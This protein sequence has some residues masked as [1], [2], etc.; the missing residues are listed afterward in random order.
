MKFRTATALLTVLALTASSALAQP[1]QGAPPPPGNAPPPGPAPG[2]SGQVLFPGLPKVPLQPLLDRVA[3]DSH[4]PF[5]VDGRVAPDLYHG[6]VRAED[7]TY[8]VL[9]SLL[10]ANDLA[11]VEIN[12]RINIV[13]LSEIR[14]L[15]TPIVQ[16]DHDELAPDEWITRIVTVKNVSSA[17]LVPILRPL[18]PQSAHLAALPPNHLIVV[19]QYGNVKR[20]TAIVKALDQP[21]AGPPKD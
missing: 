4:K 6:G 17:G 13:P 7:V 3:R 9:L 18:L 19:D 15:P 5:V 21:G 14:S 20:I 2:A 1:P 11:S 8:P 16:A 10:R 12:G